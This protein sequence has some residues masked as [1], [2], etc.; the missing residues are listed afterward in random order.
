ME[1]GLIGATSSVIL[2]PRVW[3]PNPSGSSRDSQ[4]YTTNVCERLRWSVGIRCSEHFWDSFQ[5]L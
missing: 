4:L 5:F 1:K 3:G 2:P